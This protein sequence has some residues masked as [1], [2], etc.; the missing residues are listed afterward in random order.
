MFRQNFFTRFD[1][2]LFAFT[3]RSDSKCYWLS[4][5][6]LNL[7]VRNRLPSRSPLMLN[8]R[9]SI[10]SVI[11]LAVPIEQSRFSYQSTWVGNLSQAQIWII[12]SSDSSF[13]ANVVRLNLH[14]RIR[15]GLVV[16][17]SLLLTGL[18]VTTSLMR[19]N[20]FKLH[21]FGWLLTPF[22]SAESA[23][24]TSDSRLNS[25]FQNKGLAWH[26][27][28]GFAVRPPNFGGFV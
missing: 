2:E 6:I 9:L 26:S 14:T 23:V 15:I 12:W 10:W 27:R 7:W 11:V 8:D 18:L 1:P 25:S 20:R 22:Q 16:A 3:I 28:L 4:S 24:Q 17:R 13:L 21:A 19:S 5:T